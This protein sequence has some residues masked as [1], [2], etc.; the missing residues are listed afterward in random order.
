MGKLRRA[1]IN[2]HFAHEIAS[3]YDSD[4]EAVQGKSA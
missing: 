2:T 4:R 3:M 1:T